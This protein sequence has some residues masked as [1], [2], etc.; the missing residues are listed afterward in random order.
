MNRPCCATSSRASPIIRPEIGVVSVRACEHVC[1][2]VPVRQVWSSAARTHSSSSAGS[3]ACVR[4]TRFSGSCS[5]SGYWARI[6]RGRFPEKRRCSHCSSGRTILRRIRR[7]RCG[8]RRSRSI[9]HRCRSRRRIASPATHSRRCFARFESEARTRVDAGDRRAQRRRI[10]RAELRSRVSPRG[11]R[12]CRNRWSVELDRRLRR[13]RGR[14]GRDAWSRVRDV[15]N[16]HDAAEQ[17]R[18]AL[19]YSESDTGEARRGDHR[20]RADVMG[21]SRRRLTSRR[22]SNMG[23]NV[24]ANGR[25]ILHK[26]HGKTHTCAPPDVCKTPSPGGPVPIPYVNI[27]MDS[28]LTDGAETVKIEG[29]PLANVRLQDRDQHRRRTGFGGRRHHLEQDQGD[30]DVEDGQPRREGRREERCP[31]PRHRASTTAIRSTRRSCRGRHRPGLR[32]RF[33]GGSVSDLRQA[34]RKHKILETKS[35][36]STCAEDR[37]RT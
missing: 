29:N 30:G 22:G 32:G 2:A 3:T 6:P 31:I 12:R 24:D 15:S 23:T 25:S 19:V 8:S 10:L 20:R 27:A 34:A 9:G 33:R 28:N 17:R 5:L 16:G 13:R 18:R 35:S 36:A 11:R 21:A 4:P 26:G 37:R 7:P 1:R 14:G